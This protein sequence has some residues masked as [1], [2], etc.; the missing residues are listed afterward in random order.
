MRRVNRASQFTLHDVAV[1][2][3]FLA[4]AFPVG[5]FAE[6]LGLGSGQ[7]ALVVGLA[8]YLGGVLALGIDCVPAG[9]ALTLLGL[10]A[11]LLGAL[12]CGGF[13]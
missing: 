13:N 6:R 12:L 5:G 4:A 3:L 2:I 7:I 11:V 10:A 8:L 1:V 9:I